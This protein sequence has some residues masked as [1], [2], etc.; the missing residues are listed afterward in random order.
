MPKPG[1]SF[2]NQSKKGKEP[3]T[4]IEKEENHVKGVPLFINS[5]IVFH[6]LR[7]ILKP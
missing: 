5:M 3:K 6:L 7:A 2:V 4:I 1:M